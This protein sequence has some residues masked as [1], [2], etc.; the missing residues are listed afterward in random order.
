M[1]EITK[2]IKWILGFN[3]LVILNFKLQ[4][5]NWAFNHF[6]TKNM[7]KTFLLTAIVFCLTFISCEKDEAST[8]NTPTNTNTNNTNNTGN[9]GNTNNS[10]PTG[11]YVIAKVDGV[12]FTSKDDERFEYYKSQFGSHYL[13]GKKDDT[14]AI[15]ITFWFMDPVPVG[16]YDF[17][18]ESKNTVQASYLTVNPYDTYTAQKKTTGSSG[19]V[20]VTSSDGKTMAG[21]FEFTALNN[22][23][24]K[25]VVTDGKFSLTIK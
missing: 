23:G 16:T 24:D 6:N 9:T 11:D 12:D 7:N 14:E 19:S 22:K 25:I 8:T 3:Q 17:T 2:G 4:L 5:V 15:N 20:T 18:D 21:T 10:T 13:T 1:F